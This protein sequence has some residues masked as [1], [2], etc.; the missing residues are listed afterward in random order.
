M[1]KSELE[2]LTPD[3]IEERVDAFIPGGLI[4]YD[5][6]DGGGGARD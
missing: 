2:L 1:V 4:G 6:G 3:R 5:A